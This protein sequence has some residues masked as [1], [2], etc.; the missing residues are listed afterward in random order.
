M[1]FD[2]LGEDVKEV[3]RERGFEV[4]TE[5]QEKAIPKVVSGDNLLLISPTGSGKTEA[6]A[7]PV[8]SR[9]EGGEG[10]QALYITPLR[11]LNRDIVGR[12]EWWG[13]KLGI[14]VEVRHG[15]TTS[16]RRRQQAL[17]PPDL[18][19]TTPETLQA[20]L[21]GSRMRENLGNVNHVIVDEIHDLADSK[22]GIQLALALERL[23]EAAGGFQRLGLSA[24]VGN[25]RDIMNLLV[26]VDRDCSLVL[27]EGGEPSDFLI[28]SPTYQD[29]AREV[30]RKTMLSSE[31]SSHLVRINELI[32]N[33]VSTLIFVNTRQMAETLSSRMNLLD[34]EVG[35]HHGS[36]SKDRRVEVENKF[37][38]GELDA[39]ICTSSM[40]LGIDVGHVDLVI[41]YNSPRQVFR[42]LQRV[43]RS[44]HSIEKD[45]KGVVISGDPD[46]IAES[47]VIV[48]DAIEGEM[49]NIVPRENC[50]DVLAN[51][52]CGL[53]L[54][55]DD[56]TID[57]A[58]EVFSR[59]YPYRDLTHEDVVDV[60]GLLEQGRVISRDEDRI[61]RRGSTWKYYYSNLSMIPDEKTYE[62]RDIASSRPL[63]KLDES[64]VASFAKPGE[65]FI[66]QGKMWRILNME[67]DV[68]KVEEI[69]DPQGT[70]PSWVGEEIPVPFNVAQSVGRIRRKLIDGD[71]DFNHYLIGGEAGEKLMEVVSRQTEAGYPVPT[72]NK[73]VVELG[74][75]EAIINICGGHRVNKTLGQAL[76]SLL[77]SRLGSSVG[78]D[79]DPYRIK[80][81]LPKKRSSVVKEVFPVNPDHLKPI[82]SMSLKNTSQFKWELMKVAKK[83][84]V[85]RKDADYTNY[86]TEKLMDI[87]SDTP[88][89]R[90]AMKEILNH[91][92]DIEKTRELLCQFGEEVD[93]RWCQG[94][95]PIGSLGLESGVDIISPEETSE[96]IIRTIEE[97]IENDRVLLFCI[98]C[99][100]W[101]SKKKVR[102]VRD[103]PVCPICNS[104]FIAALKPWEEEKIKKYRKEVE[105]RDVENLVKSANIVL[106][107]GRDGVIALAGRGVGPTAASRI[108]RDLPE[109]DDLYR[110]IYEEERKYARTHMFWD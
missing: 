11:A 95:S 56:L 35:V 98:N 93:V 50:Y 29:R 61:V 74:K 18:L 40:E 41:Q 36:L 21:P 78:L 106:S 16:Y 63:G 90:E 109:G 66:T 92:L 83:F 101:K 53:T 77:A 86:D 73:V 97:R 45:S 57:K 87:Y 79:V 60:L 17:D 1:S 20:I 81:K 5:P 2:F 80:L 59:A 72:D 37:K 84:G 23:E 94:F 88:L 58:L 96:S 19:V 28:E 68:I 46:D 15:D 105:D 62:V 108:L 24:T 103:D 4:A 65:V 38:E 64:F 99:E 33:H 13:E 110:K 107:H 104:K 7:L 6:I 82:L 71:V 49:E 10:I 39:L 51:Q 27:V 102:H 52:L 76:T 8:L 3:V 85:V 26:G 75:Q 55:T 12:L 9:L 70:V 69:N 91:K 31:M 48:R 25:P 67:D 89:Y 54:E 34:R 22:R 42:L 30:R 32:D 14:D 100:D 47:G 43:G 44:G